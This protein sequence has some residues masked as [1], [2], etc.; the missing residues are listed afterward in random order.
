MS[1]LLYPSHNG[2]GPRD[3]KY[4]KTR[5]PRSVSLPEERSDSV[6]G[7]DEDGVSEHVGRDAGGVVVSRGGE[8][9]GA[10]P[11]VRLAYLRSARQRGDAEAGTTHHH[12]GLHGRHGGVG[13]GR[14][15][16]PGAVHGARARPAVGRRAG[17]LGQRREQA[18]AGA[19]LK[20]PANMKLSV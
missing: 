9:P 10:G 8:A 5:P 6:H 17:H 4:L 20:V 18:E 19:A 12:R 7:S 15:G 11:A 14:R 2:P 3:D 13:V 1:L 16:G